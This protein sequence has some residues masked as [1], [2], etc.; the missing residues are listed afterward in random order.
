LSGPH[1]A[2]EF[3][4]IIGVRLCQLRSTGV[5]DGG[6]NYALCPFL[7]PGLLI[8]DPSDFA[9]PDF[10]VGVLNAPVGKR[11]FRALDVF[12]THR[13]GISVRAERVALVTSVSVRRLLDAPL[14]LLGRS[15]VVQAPEDLDALWPDI[16]LNVQVGKQPIEEQHVAIEVGREVQSP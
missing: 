11:R 15:I 16:K 1:A 6:V 10:L 4:H 9:C 12:D 8:H 7:A 2:I 13:L 5:K 14:E 3:H